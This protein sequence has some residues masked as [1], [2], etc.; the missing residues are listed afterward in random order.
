M[1]VKVN[2]TKNLKKP[3]ETGYRM[4]NTKWMSGAKV[5]ETTKSSF[6]FPFDPRDRRAFPSYVE[7]DTSVANLKTAA[8]ATWQTEWVDLPVY[9]DDNTNLTP[10]THTFVNNNIVWGK[11]KST[12]ISYVY[13]SEGGIIKRYLVNYNLD[14]IV[15]LADTGS[16]P[17]TTPVPTTTAAPTTTGA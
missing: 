3:S 15:G 17:T 1:L 6:M 13:V 2:V 7:T 12:G 14:E 11:L 10:V 4:I 9:P 16:V 8:N 5:R